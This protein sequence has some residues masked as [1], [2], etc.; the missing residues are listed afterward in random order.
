MPARDVAIYERV[1]KLRNELAHALTGMLLRELPA[2]LAERFAEMVAL[3]NK[4]ER[5]WIISVDISVNPA[6]DGKEVDAE[7]DPRPS[8]G[9]AALT[10]HRVRVG[11]RIEKIL[12]RIHQAN[13]R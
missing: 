4:F 7:N 10:G 5:W 12:R 11:R 8:H 6:F 13:W 1:K 2:E 3:L 9:I